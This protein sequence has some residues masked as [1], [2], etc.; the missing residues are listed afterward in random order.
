MRRR[1]LIITVSLAFLGLLAPAAWAD[2]PEHFTDTFPFETV[3]DCGTFTITETGTFHQVITVFTDENGEFLRAIVI[4]SYEG[5]FTLSN[6]STTYTEK[7]TH[8]LDIAPDSFAVSGQVFTIVGDNLRVYD[9]G[10]IVLDE[11]GDVV[12]A[13]ARHPLLSSGFAG[14]D[15]ALCEALAP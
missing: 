13:S 9:V 4:E 8:L 14:Q 2:T 5:E 7:G 11:N 6:S 12:F 3:T 15:A 10:R 1:A